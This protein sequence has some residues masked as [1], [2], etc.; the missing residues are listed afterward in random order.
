MLY[1]SC[2]KCK[3]I[4]NLPTKEEAPWLRCSIF[5]QATRTDVRRV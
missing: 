3:N 4:A 2:E 5:N 1:A